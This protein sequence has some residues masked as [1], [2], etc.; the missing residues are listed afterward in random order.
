[1]PW[2]GLVASGIQYRVRPADEVKERVP[3]SQ[4][5][6]VEP[7]QPVQVSV[8]VRGQLPVGRPSCM[9]LR[10]VQWLRINVKFGMH[11]SETLA[12][13]SGLCSIGNA[14][15]TVGLQTNAQDIE[16][17]PDVSHMHSSLRFINELVI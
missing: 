1:M 10:K 3:G 13:F 14:W 5:L 15:D 9:M 11:A 7:I 16:S 17:M 8:C 12:S 6:P 4:V 2:W